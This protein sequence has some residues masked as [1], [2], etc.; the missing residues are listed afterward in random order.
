MR[1]LALALTLALAGTAVANERT[2]T[3]L[4]KLEQL[5]QQK[6]DLENRNRVAIIFNNE[7]PI[8][9]A[10]QKLIEETGILFSQKGHTIV[11][12]DS[13]AKATASHA[14]NAPW[15]NEE[16]AALADSLGVETIV[17][18]NLKEFKAKKGFGL[19][20]P[21]MWVR[22][23]ANVTVE[24]AVYQRSKNNIVWKDTVSRHRRRYVGGGA[25]TRAESRRNMGYSVVDDLYRGY[26][27][28]RS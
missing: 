23:D 7:T 1:F 9:G 16:L 12:Q 11:S 4:S 22:T 28:R 24:G 2:D 27:N 18:G 15:T 8:A 25:I 3:A 21:T 14:K 19:P 10:E 26:L 20:L 17:I 6:R 13:V 5:R